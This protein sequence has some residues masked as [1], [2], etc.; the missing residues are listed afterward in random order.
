MPISQTLRAA[1]A[2]TVRHAPVVALSTHEDIDT[3]RGGRRREIDTYEL[4][5][6]A[7][8]T[9]RVALATSV[10]EVCPWLD[11]KSGAYWVTELWQIHRVMLALGIDSED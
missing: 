2:M 5:A 10:R 4:H 3:R 7:I 1:Q 6:D 9:I 11:G 8:D